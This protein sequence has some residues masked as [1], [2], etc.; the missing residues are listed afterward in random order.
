MPCAR[1]I[2]HAWKILSGSVC[3]NLE[4][5]PISDYQIIHEDFIVTKKMM[6]NISIVLFPLVLFI[7]IGKLFYSRKT[8]RTNH[9]VGGVIQ[10]LISLTLK[11]YNTDVQGFT[12]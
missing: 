8:K 9:C 2:R 11:K 5:S 12:I 3:Y 10:L 7:L 1:A 4:I 6:K